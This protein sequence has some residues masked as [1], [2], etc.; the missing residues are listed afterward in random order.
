MP[1]RTARSRLDGTSASS[2]LLNKAIPLVHEI[3]FYLRKVMVVV[4]LTYKLFQY[5]GIQ[6]ERVLFR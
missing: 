4:W 2:S 6:K 1:C 3:V 5:E